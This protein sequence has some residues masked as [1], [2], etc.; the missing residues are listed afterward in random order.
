[1]ALAENL[2]VL[3]L[4]EAEDVEDRGGDGDRRLAVRN[5][6]GGPG[7]HA[8]GLVRAKY[9][10]MSG[11][12]SQN[13][14]N[15]Q[16]SDLVFRAESEQCACATHEKGSMAKRSA[17]VLP[18]GSGMS[19]RT[20]PTCQRWL[21]G[22]LAP[23]EAVRRRMLMARSAPARERERQVEL[24]ECSAVPAAASAAPQAQTSAHAPETLELE[25]VHSTSHGW[26]SKKTSRI[27]FASLASC[28]ARSP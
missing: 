6:E 3:L 16:A 28:A 5:E 26:P 7:R 25:L 21:A 18:E 23:M 10:A 13:A 15:A 22:M 24:S 27:W 4:V 1:M 17:M 11:M 9:R 12:Q 14:R 20:W 2:H 19:Q 8:H